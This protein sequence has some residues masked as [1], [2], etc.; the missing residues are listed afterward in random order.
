MREIDEAQFSDVVLKSET[1][2]LVEFVATWCGP[3]RLI[4]PAV[5]SL[6]QVSCSRL[7]GIL[8]NELLKN[9]MSRNCYDC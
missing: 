9:N 3:C 7:S 6:A 5:Q 1:P 4:A 8:W 2:V